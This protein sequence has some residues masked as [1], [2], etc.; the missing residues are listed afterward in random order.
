M[1]RRWKSFLGR[2]LSINHLRRRGSSR[3]IKLLSTISVILSAC[4]PRSGRTCRA[5]HLNCLLGI[6]VKSTPDDSI[7]LKRAQ[8]TKVFESEFPILN[9]KALRYSAELSHRFQYC[10]SKLPVRRDSS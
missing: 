2:I 10:E 4:A 6:A 9:S 3:Y 7:C 5:N 1:S 8:G